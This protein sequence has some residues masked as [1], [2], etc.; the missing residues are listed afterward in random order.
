[1]IKGVSFQID[2]HWSISNVQVYARFFSYDACLDQSGVINVV[3]QECHVLNTTFA[4][5]LAYVHLAVQSDELAD[6]LIWLYDIHLLLSDMTKL[7]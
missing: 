7:N 4:L 5:I 3:R 1:M 6:R 2:V